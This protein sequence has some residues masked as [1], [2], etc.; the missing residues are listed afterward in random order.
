M[1]LAWTI[2]ISRMY[3]KGKYKDK[4]FSS[5]NNTSKCH[6]KG[7]NQH[8][9]T[10][11]FGTGALPCKALLPEQLLSV[12]SATPHMNEIMLWIFRLSLH[13]SPAVHVLK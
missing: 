12:V 8:K 4:V 9:D 2:W 11:Y 5:N 1:I 10:R 6:T 13:F 7:H 3:L